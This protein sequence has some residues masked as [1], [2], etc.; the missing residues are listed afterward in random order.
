M[1]ALGLP[2]YI[3]IKV[4]ITCYFSREDTKTPLYISIATVLLN[5][6]LSILLIQSMRE[7]GIALATSISA[8]F[9]VFLLYFILKYRNYIALDSRLMTNSMKII[10]GS[11]IMGLVCYFLN[12]SMFNQMEN[13]SLMANIMALLLIII[14]CKIIYVGMIFMLKVLKISEIREYI[15]K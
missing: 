6:L 13:H 2:A 11:A 4:L 14:V 3:L 15:K 8:W 9:N 1:F 5:I 12:I 7:M 10:I